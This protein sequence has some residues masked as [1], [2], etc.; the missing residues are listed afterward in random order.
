MDSNIRDSGITIIGNIPWG[1]HIGLLYSSK[2]DFFDVMVPYIY[3]GL[4]NNELCIWIYADNTSFGEIKDNLSEWVEDVDSYLKRGQLQIVPY[5]QWYLK[6][7]NFNDIR[8]N[9]QW[10]ELIR[11]A[12]DSGYDG[13]R[14][15]GD[16]SWLQESFYRDFEYYEQNINNIISDL[17]FIVMCLYDV[18]K[19]DAMEIAQIIKNHSYVITKHRN[20]PY[21]IKNVEL[22]IKDEQIKKS[23]KRYKDLIRLIPDCIFVHDEKRIFYCN[24]S[25]KHIVGHNDPDGLLGMSILQFAPVEMRYA[26]KK[27]IEEAMSSSKEYNYIQS[28][29]IWKNGEIRDVQVIS[30]RYDFQG[31]STLLSVVRDIT[32]FNRISELERDIQKNKEMLNETLEYDRI[33][34]EF[35]SNISHELR[36]PLNVIFSTVQ[37]LKSKEAKGDLSIKD[38]KYLKTIQQNCFRLLRLINN[39]IDITKIDSGYF[40]LQLQN[41]NIIS[42]VENITMS[43]VD[44][45]RNRGINIFFDTNTEEKIMACDP[46]QIERIIL[47]LLSNAIKYTQRDGIIWVSV[48]DLGERIKIAIK[49]TGI[50]IP[51]DKQKCIFDRFKHVDSSLRR[52]YEGSGIGLS[53]VKAL[54]EKHNGTITLNSQL[55]KGSEFIIEIPCT[56]LTA[57]E[58]Q[59]SFSRD[60]ESQAHVEKINIEFSDI[61]L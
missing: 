61:Y 39:L 22:L 9:R 54:V 32:P 42:L 4:I 19:L 28:K 1:T 13:L 52:C 35:F 26:L 50:G 10:N 30:T 37:L 34:T 25:A 5:T 60:I 7:N 33:K 21:L 47:N 57:A 55:G 59:L 58:N 49:D 31:H 12:L 44:Y 14:A 36:T 17:S 40:E 45:A 8:V 3:Q 48:S 2:A 27:F 53:I 29:L 43:I 56:V 46:D 18:N 16:T 15:I 24:E 11:H 38:S 41:Y 20:Q 51:L 6:D 23:E